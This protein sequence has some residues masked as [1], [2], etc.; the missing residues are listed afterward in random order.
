VHRAKTVH[1]KAFIRTYV[2]GLGLD[3]HACMQL[4]LGLG[5]DVNVHMRELVDKIRVVQGVSYVII[6]LDDSAHEY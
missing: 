4:G 2:L 5:L 6:I 3:V 1:R